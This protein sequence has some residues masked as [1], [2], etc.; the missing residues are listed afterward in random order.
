MNVN[1]IKVVN[2]KTDKILA[3][4]AVERGSDEEVMI[5]DSFIDQDVN[6]TKATEV[7][8]NE[9]DGEV[10]KKTGKATFCHI[11]PEE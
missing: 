7:E 4:I 5:V 11:L 9:F 3:V 6:F 1:F 2:P 8:F 10:V